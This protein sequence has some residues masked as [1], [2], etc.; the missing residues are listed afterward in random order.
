MDNSPSTCASAA[1]ARA[2]SA[3]VLES[4]SAADQQLSGRIGEQVGTVERL[5]TAGHPGVAIGLLGPEVVFGDAQPFHRE[6]EFDP[7]RQRVDKRLAWRSAASVS[8]RRS[9]RPRCRR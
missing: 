3:S 7:L 6:G 4:R 2:A 1:A 5:E 8:W 9:R